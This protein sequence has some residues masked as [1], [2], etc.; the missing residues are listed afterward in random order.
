MGSQ[1]GRPLSEADVINRGFSGYNTEWAKIILPELVTS[2]PEQAD[3]VTVFF[4][5]NDASLP[6]PNPLQHVPLA[7]FKSNM[8]DIITLLTSIGIEK[9]SIVLITPPPLQEDLWGLECKE[10]GQPMDRSNA[11]TKQYAEAVLQLGRETGLTTVDVYNE[12]SKEQ[13]LGQLLS[14]GLHFTPEGNQFLADLIIPVL[15]TKL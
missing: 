6:E 13:N 10:K 11:A 4:G 14:D 9:S 7:A 2:K 1:S 5:A 3:V 8:N 12:M 15:E